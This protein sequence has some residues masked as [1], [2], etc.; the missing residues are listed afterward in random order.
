M[1]ELPRMTNALAQLLGREAAA[2]GD[3]RTENDARVYCQGP[4]ARGVKDATLRLQIKARKRLQA[5]L[6]AHRAQSKGDT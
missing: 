2:E 3:T 4:M 6:S 5:R 1:A